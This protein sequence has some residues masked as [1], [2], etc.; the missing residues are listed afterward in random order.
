MQMRDFRKKFFRT[1]FSISII[2]IF[3][4]DV[5]LPKNNTLKLIKDY[6]EDIKHTSSEILSN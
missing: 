3:S 4:T 6:L 1:I 5:V 2:F